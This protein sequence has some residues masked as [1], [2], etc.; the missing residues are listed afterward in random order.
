MAEPGLGWGEL[1]ARLAAAFRPG[2]WGDAPPRA[3]DLGGARIA[4]EPGAPV[5]LSLRE[6]LLFAHADTRPWGP[7]Y[8][9]RAVAVLDALGDALPGGWREVHD[10]TG[11]YARRDRRALEGVFLRWACAGWNDEDRLARAAARGGAAREGGPAGSVSTP[12]G[13]RSLAW[14]V[15]TARALRRAVEEETRPLEPQARAAFLWWRASPDAFDWMQLGLAACARS[16]ELA[17]GGEGAAVRERALWCFES[18][19]LLDPGAPAVRAQLARLY[20]AL[21][22]SAEPPVRAAAGERRPRAPGAGPEA[23]ASRTEASGGAEGCPSA[24]STALGARW[25]LLL[26]ERLRRGCDPADGHEVFWDDRM[27]VRVTVER[28]APTAFRPREQAR[29][30]LGLLPPAWR[31]G[32]QVG[33]FA[34]GGAEGY[35]LEAPAG[36]GVHLVAGQVG[37]GDERVTFTVVARSAEARLHALRFGRGL[38]PLS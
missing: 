28:G 16:A 19:L 1:R 31:E 34:G 21:G 38:R 6:G 32:A 26:P 2:E 30:H 27:T 4:V 10:P 29:R 11:Y 8:H 23:L 13:P 12:L 36:P 24:H 35:L 3:G 15:R 7:G 33:F 37:R 18:A 5:L 17:R 20:G 14:V 9:E 25:R 22:R